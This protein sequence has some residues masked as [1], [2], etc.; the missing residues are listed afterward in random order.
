LK[1]SNPLPEE[2][3]NTTQTHPLKELL[4]LTSGL[5]ALIIVSVL[6]LGALAD[7]LAKYIPFQAEVAISQSMLTSWD[8]QEGEVQTYLQGLA[9]RLATAQHMPKH[10]QVTIHYVDD[11][12]VNAMATL[13]GHIVMFRG[14]LSKLN[15]ENAVAMVLAHE[16]AHIQHRHPIQT[17][18][19]GAII[20]IAL[21][22]LGVSAG[23]AKQILGQ[24][25]LITALTFSRHQEQVAD[26]T[27][28]Q[29]LENLY[30]HVHG[31][32]DLFETIIQEE[33]DISIR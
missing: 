18:S 13:G 12:T 15:S 24:T 26:F 3:I 22:A 30:G 10:M 9:D 28:L 14:L 25:G 2:G 5:L 8:D 4:I 33:K 17:L 32:T 29:S 21:S 19:R 16:I 23:D 7:T 11:K 27:A 20:S 1:Y 6:I 31:A